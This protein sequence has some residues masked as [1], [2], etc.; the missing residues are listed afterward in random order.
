MTSNCDETDL[1]S[2]VKVEAD[3]FEDEIIKER[4]NKGPKIF[5]YE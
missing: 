3:L 1:E 2:I 5:V 4:K